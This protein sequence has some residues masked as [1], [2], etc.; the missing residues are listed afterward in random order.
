MPGRP[1][2]FVSKGGPLSQSVSGTCL[3]GKA[4]RLAF[5]SIK[6]NCSKSLL[7]FSN[8][9]NKQRGV[10]NKIKATYIL[11][12]GEERPDSS[13]QKLARIATF[14]NCEYKNRW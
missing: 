1:N 11:P 14:F 4:K 10:Y 2:G 12:V 5:E 8:Y 9:I 3:V 13:V 6:F 7:I